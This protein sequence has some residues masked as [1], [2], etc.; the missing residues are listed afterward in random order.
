MISVD[1]FCLYRCLGLCLDLDVGFVL[2][3]HAGLVLLRGVAT[4]GEPVLG[5]LP[6]IGNGHFSFYRRRE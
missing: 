3:N 5:G 4:G 6:K 2:G 1:F